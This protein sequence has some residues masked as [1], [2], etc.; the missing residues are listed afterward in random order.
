MP[1]LLQ[2][3]QMD[4]I[5]VVIEVTVTEDDVVADLSTVTTKQLILRKP[6]GDELTKTAL[7]TTNGSD[8]KLRY[9]T[10]AGDLDHIGTWKVQPYLVFPGGFDG[11]IDH[12]SFRVK[13]NI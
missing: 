3:V 8:G 12:G 10:I 13:A 1:L 11:R 6:N 7:F 2:Q 4:A 5:G 9:T